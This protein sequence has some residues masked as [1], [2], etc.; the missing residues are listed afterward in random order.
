MRSRARFRRGRA[1]SAIVAVALLTSACNTGDKEAAK[2]AAPGARKGGVL[3]V[4]LEEPASIESG[5][6]FDAAGQQLVQTMCDPLI[7]IDPITGEL[8]PAIAESWQLSG[9]GKQ[10]TVKIRK[11]VKFHNGTKVTADDVAFTLSRVAS[12]QYAS[13]QAPLLS[14]VEGYELVHGDEETKDKLKRRRLGGVKIIEGNSFEIK[15]KSDNA[16]FIRLLTHPLAAP[17]SRKAAEADPV[18]FARQPICA[19]PYKMAKPWVPGDPTISLVRFDDY[20]ARNTGYTA[21]GTGYVDSIEVSLHDDKVAAAAAYDGGAADVADLPIDRVPEIRGSRPSELVEGITPT[22][23]YIGLPATARDSPFADVHV[24]RALSLALDRETI[25]QTVYN[26]SRKPASGFVGPSVGKEW[27]R[28]DACGEAVPPRADVAAAQAELAEAG[29]LAQTL[30]G[31]TIPLTFNDEL[32][33]R[34][35]VEAVAQQWQA[36]LGLQFEL[37]PME[38]EKYLS[39][40][41]GQEGFRGPFRFSWTPAYPSSDLYLAPVFGSAGIGRD[42]FSRFSDGVFDRRLER[43]A[44]RAGEV[45]DRLAE[46]HQLEDLLCEQLPMLPLVYGGSRFLIRTGKVAVATESATERGS[47]LLALRELY[48]AA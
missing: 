3:R 26:G 13:F 8:K 6:V 39:Q 4:A 44:R 11:G 28:S 25:A 23:E 36:A 27:Y 37:V 14:N 5:N 35:V 48:L 17:V 24:R 31:T 10:M 12:D 9:G 47:G 22:I 46:Y 42:N 30:K 20:Y 1:A 16:D 15:L 19:G 7:Q 43:Q 29:Q 33:N 38:W 21:G 2:P 41:I 18:K 40:A 34:R 32:D 45:G